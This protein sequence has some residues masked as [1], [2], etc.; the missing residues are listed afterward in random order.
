MYCQ[1]LFAVYNTKPMTPMKIENIVKAP[2]TSVL[3]EEE[4]SN[5]FSA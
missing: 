5:V 4:I 1:S 3:Y 2:V